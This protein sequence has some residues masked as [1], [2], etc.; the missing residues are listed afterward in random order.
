MARKKRPSK[1]TALRKAARKPSKALIATA[2]AVTDVVFHLRANRF[3][4]CLELPDRVL[5]S[6]ASKAAN[7]RLAIRANY[8]VWK[9]WCLAQKPARKPYPADARD[10]A[11]FLQAQAPPI[12]RMA[13]STL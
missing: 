6:I 2:P 12:R 4:D 11:G 13:S 10:V 7:T 5:R 1:V 3:Q 8:K 9:S